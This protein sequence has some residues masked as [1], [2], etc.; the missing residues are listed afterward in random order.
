MPSANAIHT[1][2]NHFIDLHQFG[3]HVTWGAMKK[4]P[5]FTGRFFMSAFRASEES[6][7]FLMA[8]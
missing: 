3:K 7:V 2:P 8:I 1:H 4:C 5:V 6:T